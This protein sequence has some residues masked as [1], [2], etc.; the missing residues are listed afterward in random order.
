MPQLQKNFDNE[1]ENPI[2]KC[3]SRRMKQKAADIPM[4]KTLDLQV[5]NEEKNK[6]IV[7]FNDKLQEYING[8]ELKEKSNDELE[9]HFLLKSSI[10][11][12][13]ELNSEIVIFLK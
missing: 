7:M 9:D 3:S 13:H 10:T 8:Y 12:T 6:K 1:S 2:I 11:I 4:I 5:S